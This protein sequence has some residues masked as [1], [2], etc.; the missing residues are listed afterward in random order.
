MR[1]NLANNKGT[2]QT[3]HP[4]SLISDFIMHYLEILTIKRATSKMSVF[5]LVPVAEKSGLM[6]TLS[7]PPNTEFLA[8]RPNYNTYEI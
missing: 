2:D 4:H 7:Q 3:V 5:E 8:L 1:E 6:L